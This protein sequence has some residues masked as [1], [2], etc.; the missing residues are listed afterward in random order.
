MLQKEIDQLAKLGCRW[1]YGH[2][3]SAYLD[4]E[5]DARA[6]EVIAGHLRECAR[7]RAEFEQ[8][9]FANTALAEFEIPPT[10]G[11][12]SSELVFQLP[13]LKKVSRLRRLY[14]QKIAVPLPLAAGIAIT[15]ISASLFAISRNQ[16]API[17][18]IASVPTPPPAVIKVV[19]V[20]VERVVTRTV[21]SRVSVSKRVRGIRKKNEF[22]LTP[23]GNIAQNAGRTVEWSDRTLKEFRPASS[24]NLR[25]VK[26]HEK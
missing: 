13:V 12:L 4:H 3:L 8:L 24:A 20:P 15:L 18:S 17:Q 25:V 26:E 11:P 21:Y 14:S 19:Q 23:S 10:R 2:M 7:C 22:T 16:R 1:R 6:E 9:R 5:L